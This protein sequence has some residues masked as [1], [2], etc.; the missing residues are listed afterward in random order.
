MRKISILA[1]ICYSI[2]VILIIIAVVLAWIGT[3]ISHGTIISN[4]IDGFKGAFRARKDILVFIILLP[5]VGYLFQKRYN[6]IRNEA[7]NKEK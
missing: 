2:F 4:L 5:I 7:A 3:V 6:K 1:L